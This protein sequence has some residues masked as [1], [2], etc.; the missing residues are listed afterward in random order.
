MSDDVRR[1]SEELARNPGSLVFL[2]LG[3]LLRRNHQL[4]LAL[5]V[6]LRGLERHADNVDAHDL[7]ARIRADQG[8]FERALSGWDTVLRA[9]PD[10]IGARK[11]KG[12]VLFRQGRWDEAAREL[13][14]AA[15]WAPHDPT[16]AAALAQVQRRAGS[17][18][19]APAEP[20][21][22][23][24]AEARR[25]FAESLGETDMTAL[26]IDA[27]GLVM[28]GAYPTADG[29]DVAQEIGAELSGVSDEVQRAM[30]HLGLGAW[31]AISFETDAATV[32]M[33]PAPDDS[34]VMLAADPA[35]PQGL[36]RRT[37]DRCV[38]RSR[39]W[40]AGEP[41]GGRA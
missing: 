11:G 1:L 22:S 19:P 39:S 24:A 5:R 41:V 20:R 14:R 35:L 36:V 13:E 25:L 28:A 12:Y 17:G 30:R 40:L 6:S 37:L 4:D 34:L 8:D 15:E 32:A 16:I 23:A 9:V 10:H 31:T 7:V 3:E 27:N 26:L 33:A 18:P 21:P 29:G 38:A 2:Q